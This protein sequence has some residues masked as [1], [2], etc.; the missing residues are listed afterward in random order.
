MNSDSTSAPQ[1]YVFVYGTLRKS[2]S[3]AWRMIGATFLAA[4]TTKG[5]LYR[6][7]W[8]P[9]AIFDDSANSVIVGELYSLHL[10]QLQALDTFEGNEYHRIKISVTTTQQ[11]YA[12]AWEYID[13]IE[14]LTMIVSGDWLTER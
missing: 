5:H 4:A 13:P 12:W 7:D 9:A 1:E 2:G 14:N 8:Y 10:D 6:V 11:V 3:N